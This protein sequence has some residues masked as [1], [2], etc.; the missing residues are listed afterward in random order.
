MRVF[1]TLRDLSKKF[2]KKPAQNITS[3]FSQL[4]IL[5]WPLQKRSTSSNCTI[6][7]I[8]RI[9]RKY[10]GQWSCCCKSILIVQRSG[11]ER[12]TRSDYIQG[13][14]SCERDNL[15]SLLQK[16]PISGHLSHFLTSS[17]VYR[18]MRDRRIY[19]KILKTTL[20]SV[21]QTLI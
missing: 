4:L 9:S 13:N 11:H 7:V 5:V 18:C 14:S 8:W 19:M 6:K 17:K 1:Q 20:I 12:Q 21:T 3:D 2:W 16:W 10:R 15:N